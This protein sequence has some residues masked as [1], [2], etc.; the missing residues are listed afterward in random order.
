MRE[1]SGE[2]FSLIDLMERIRR[3]NRFSRTIADRLLAYLKVPSAIKECQEASRLSGLSFVKW[4]LQRLDIKVAAVLRGEACGIPSSGPAIIVSNHPTGLTDGLALMELVG[5][6]RSDVRVVVNYLLGEIEEV[7]SVLDDVFIYVNP[8]DRHKELKSSHSG[9]RGMFKLLR[10]GGVV[11]F[12]PAG[13]VSNFSWRNLRLADNPWNAT[14]SRLIDRF[15]MPVI[16]VY[17][18]NR[19]SR[20][21]YLLNKISSKLG[22]ALL[23]R[24][25]FKQGGRTIPIHIGQ[26][27]VRMPREP[28]E[29]F[30]DRLRA[31][32]EAL[33]IMRREV[34]R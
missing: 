33:A 3:L 18:A 24:E 30:A 8:F 26:P 31:E 23:L 4:H 22:L 21:F 6:E 15:D 10:D 9:L 16:P 28:P 7:G 34:I 2:S 13:D 17:I 14:F 27:R 5:Q 29:A 19:N 25:H 12:F 32:M 11:I 20:W 1:I